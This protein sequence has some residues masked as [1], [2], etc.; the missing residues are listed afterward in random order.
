MRLQTPAI[1]LVVICTLLSSC[2]V[3]K[4]PIDL[5][6]AA[7]KTTGKVACATCEMT[8]DVASAIGSTA[9]S[10]ATATRAVADVATSPA[11]QEVA[12]ESQGHIAKQI[13]TQAIK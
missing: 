1:M 4:A 6:T 10:V 12:L 11:V 2:S 5:T 3:V 13:V 9:N 7:I 8:G